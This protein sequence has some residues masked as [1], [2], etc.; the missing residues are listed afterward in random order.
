MID[1]IRG[2]ETGIDPEWQPFVDAMLFME[3][4]L[5]IK[6]PDQKGFDRHSFFAANGELVRYYGDQTATLH[7]IVLAMRGEDVSTL[8]ELTGKKG[9]GA[10]IA[11]IR[12]RLPFGMGKRF[13]EM[14]QGSDL[15]LAMTNA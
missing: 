8:A 1:A 9:V 15:Y 6:A 2:P 14:K 7:G 5:G 13:A 11:H 3:Q 4:H 12:E 10:V